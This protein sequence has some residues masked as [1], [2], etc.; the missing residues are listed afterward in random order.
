MQLIVDENSKKSLWRI[1]VTKNNKLIFP[2]N[3]GFT[4][5][6]SISLSPL[7]KEGFELASMPFC[8]ALIAS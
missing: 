5:I 3:F 4:Y 2:K 7:L 8:P 1:I 6:E